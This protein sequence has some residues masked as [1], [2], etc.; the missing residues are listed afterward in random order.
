MYPTDE[1]GT[2]DKSGLLYGFKDLQ[3]QE[4]VAQIAPIIASVMGGT[5]TDV[6]E[7]TTE[8]AVALG[9]SA[10]SGPVAE[11]KKAFD[12]ASAA[13]TEAA[14]SGIVTQPIYA[15]AANVY[16]AKA[17]HDPSL[18]VYSDLGM[19][20]VEPQ[21]D[22]YYWDII[23][24]EKYDTIAG[25]L[26][27]YSQH[28]LGPEQLRKQPTF[29]ASPAAKADQIQPWVF[30]GMDYPSQAAYMTELAGWLSEAKRV[31]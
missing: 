28:G 29:A 3:Q 5:A 1:K 24:R 30:A 22:D 16:I 11:G 12:Q 25:D 31:S 19:K 13:L 4:Q 15:E 10:D 18:R 9:A 23:S 17:P 2:I 27:L 26:V 6:I 14:K 20:F 7:R 8:L 21:T